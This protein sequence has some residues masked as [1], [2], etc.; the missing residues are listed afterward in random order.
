MRL[1]GGECKGEGAPAPL[2]DHAGLCAI[3]AARAAKR[4]THISLTAVDPLA[5]T[6]NFTRMATVAWRTD[7]AAWGGLMAPAEARGTGLPRA[8]VFRCCDPEM[9]IHLFAYL[10]GNRATRLG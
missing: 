2:R 7:P 5:A 6:V 8:A 3:A 9:P 10:W 4:L 1:P